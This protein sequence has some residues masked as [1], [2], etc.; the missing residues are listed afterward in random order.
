MAKTGP[1]IV[2]DPGKERTRGNDALFMNISAAKAVAGLVQSTL[3]PKGMDKMLINK[4]GQVSM[5]NDGANILKD[6]GI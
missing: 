3:G 2:L 6:I 1:I 4:M 5:T